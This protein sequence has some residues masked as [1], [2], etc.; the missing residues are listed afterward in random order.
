MIRFCDKEVYSANIWELTRGKLMMHFCQ[1]EHNLDIIM[2]YGAENEWKGFVSYDLLL[3]RTS[4]EVEDIL[5]SRYMIKGENLMEH[6]QQFFMENPEEVWLIVCDKNR[7][8]DCFLYNDIRRKAE[9]GAQNTALEV[10]EKGIELL[11]IE[12][13]YPQMQAAVIYDCNEWADRWYRILKKR[14]IPVKLVGE[15]WK[16]LYEEMPQLTE[17]YPDY[18]IMNIYAEGSKCFMEQKQ[19]D[20]YY[21]NDASK[22]FLFL[23]QLMIA[24]CRKRVERFQEERKEQT[25]VCKIPSFSSLESFSAE[26]YFRFKNIIPDN[27][28]IRNRLSEKELTKV[29]GM[30]V[31]KYKKE[32][33]RQWKPAKKLSGIN[34]MTQVTEGAHSIYL[35]GPCIVSGV[36]ALWKDT[37]MVQLQKL[38]EEMQLDYGVKAIVCEEID[39]EQLNE[40]LTN[41]S[42]TSKD[43]I[44]FIERAEEEEIEGY[45]IEEADLDLLELY[46]H[47]PKETPWFF[48]CPIH[49]NAHGNKAVAKEIFDKLIVPSAKNL[50]NKKEYYIQKGNLL[51][52]KYKENLKCYLQMIKKQ[53]ADIPNYSKIGAIVMNC[54]PFTLGHQYLVE[55]A[56]K[57]VDYLYLF[58][59]QENRSVFPF[60]DR[61]K[62]VEAGTAQYKNVR[63]FPSGEFI[64]S[65]HTLPSYFQKEELQ[66][67]EIDATEDVELFSWYIAPPLHIGVRFAGEEPFDNVTN[68]YNRTMEQILVRHGIEFVEIHR[69]EQAGKPISASLV[70]T[71]LTEKKWDEIS[72][73]V[74]QTTLTYLKQVKD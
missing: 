16:L 59:V 51:P 47:R 21:F 36:G 11:R 68:Q 70:R 6:A 15:K 74:P 71:L 50:K 27:E 56:S 23:R 63:V 18:A 48:D 67:V 62:L 1:K 9:Y 45:Q 66:N 33:E 61:I 5:E 69:K 25:F 29:Y 3:Q 14:K 40:I 8:P 46:N 54:N 38:V 52:E 22:N 42:I 41:I 26:E 13:V 53:T 19:K 17:P 20:G 72:K 65:Y 57:Q 43:M 49:T 39:Y 32:K 28:D 7:Q 4:M 30:S 73:L 58:V 60:E 34:S 2:V 35:I 10:F 37:L 55:Y 31:E 12:E 44:I 64:L 24:N